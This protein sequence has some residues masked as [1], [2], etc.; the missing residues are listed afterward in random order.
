MQYH[1]QVTLELG[2]RSQGMQMPVSLSVWS[3][4]CQTRGLDHLFIAD[5]V[6]QQTCLFSACILFCCDLSL[7]FSLLEYFTYDNIQN[8]LASKLDRSCP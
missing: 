8:S 4:A 3:Q 7:S 1:P 5:T 6:E 2:I